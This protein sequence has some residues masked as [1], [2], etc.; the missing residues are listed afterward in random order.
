MPSQSQITPEQSAAITR[1]YEHDETFLIAPLGFGKA[2]VGLTALQELVQA[3]VLSR[4]L[5]IG[6]L[7][8]ITNTWVNE[9]RDWD[10][11]D[12]S[13]C[14]SAVGGPK[15]RAAAIASGKPI[16]L[17]N[18]ESVGA[19]LEEH[20][21]FDGMLIDELTRLKTS[22]GNTFKELRKFVK[23]LRWRAGMTATPVA[24]STVDIYGQ[25]LLID[26]GKAL[27]TRKDA[28]LNEHFT[29]DFTGY[30][31]TLRPGAAE[32]IAAR[33]GAV[34]YVA[35]GAAYEASLPVLH[36]RTIE[37]EMSE[38]ARAYYDEIC[39]KSVL[40]VDG[41][42]VSAVNAATLAGK[43]NT[44]ACGGLYG[45]DEDESAQL[46]W[47]CPERRRA[48]Q[49]LLRGLTE[50][51]LIVYNYTFELDTVLDL[52]PNVPVLGGRGKAGAREIEAFNQGK[53]HLVGHP[54]SLG[55]GL[56]LQ[57]GCR[58]VLLLSPITSADL[59]KQTIGRVHRRGQKSD[60]F[61][62]TITT[63]GTVQDAWS[64]KMRGKQAV[65]QHTMQALK[66]TPAG[67][68]QRA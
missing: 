45:K 28:F 8:V 3:G 68:H 16:V 18:V 1:L 54:K 22:G 64:V 32:V 60:C 12:A 59:R 33:M 39:D 25:T 4:V 67:S 57:R 31:I 56:N 35:D 65:E 19:L 38:Q 6:P 20:D 27:G 37:I 44:I 5:V 63:P 30:N 13:L 34:L 17:I 42:T 47:H 24:E 62:D 55:M 48:V 51:T 7:Q 61:V 26:L 11:L 14:V 41:A 40:N 53:T 36:E 43:K 2:V 66:K 46:L 21:Q 50:T 49:D 52:W 29:V 9:A 15:Q 58:Q 10:H 23:K